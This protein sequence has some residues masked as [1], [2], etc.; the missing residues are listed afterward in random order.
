MLTDLSQQGYFLAVAT[1][2][3]RVGLN[4]AMNSTGLLS[5]FD[6]TRCAD[7]TFSKPHP[8][9]LQELTRTGPGHAP[10]RDDR[11]HHPRPA[12]GHQ[13]RRAG[14]A[15]E[16]GAHPPQQLQALAPL[17]SAKSIRELHQWLN[18]HA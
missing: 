16:F 7:E 11:R 1:G 5:A 15:V 4:R 9:M 10:H 6:A 8:A 17:Y 13:R 2:K 12:D 18:D 14:V 3:S